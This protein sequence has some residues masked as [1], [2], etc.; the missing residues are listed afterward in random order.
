MASWKEHGAVLAAFRRGSYPSGLNASGWSEL[1][2]AFSDLAKL[3]DKVD[4]NWAVTASQELAKAETLLSDFDADPPVLW[5]VIR[6][7]VL[8]RDYRTAP[9]PS[10]RS[11]AV[12]VG[13]ASLLV[14]LQMFGLT[15]SQDE[16]GWVPVALYIGLALALTTVVLVAAAVVWRVTE[17]LGI[18][19]PSVSSD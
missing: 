5:S 15:H 13:L 9:V 11:V 8:G 14:A 3:D 2:R 1:A 6:S 10:A 19:S 12:L 17:S 16:R 7:G 18:E 4:H